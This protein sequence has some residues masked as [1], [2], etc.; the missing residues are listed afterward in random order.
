[1]AATISTSNVVR[2]MLR[3]EDARDPPM[4]YRIPN[5]FS[6]DVTSL[7]VSLRRSILAPFFTEDLLKVASE[8]PLRGSQEDFPIA[9]RRIFLPESRF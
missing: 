8:L 9:G 3:A 2:Q 5:R 7:S 4:A 6:A 1:M